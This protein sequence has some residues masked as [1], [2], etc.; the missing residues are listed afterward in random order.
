ML[1]NVRYGKTKTNLLFTSFLFRMLIPCLVVTSNLIVI[2]KEVIQSTILKV[3]QSNAS[4]GGRIG[5]CRYLHCIAIAIHAALLWG[6]ASSSPTSTVIDLTETQSIS[7]YESVTI[8][9]ATCSTLPSFV[10][11]FIFRYTIQHFFTSIS[12]L[13]ADGALEKFVPPPMTSI[14]I[15]SLDL[16]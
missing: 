9:A 1:L 6:G 7:P 11:H 12:Y 4:T 2:V 3:H 14:D 15:Q 5:E 13:F 10:F 8:T 16:M